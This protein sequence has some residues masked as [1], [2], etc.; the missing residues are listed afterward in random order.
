MPKKTKYFQNCLGVFQGGGVKAIAYVGAYEEAIKRGVFF[1]E[2]VG[3]S[4]GSAIASLIAVGATPDDF[5]KII[6]KL[7]FEKFLKPPK[8]IKGIKYNLPWRIPLHS[9]WQLGKVRRFIR[10]LG[11]YDPSYISEWINEEL[12]IVLNKDKTEDSEGFIPKGEIVKFKHLLI[13][14]SIVATNFRTKRVHIWNTNDNLDD[15]VADAVKASS[16]IPFYFQPIELKY[17]DGGMLSNLPSFTLKPET[18]FDKILAFGFDNEEG[19]IS[20]ITNYKQYFGDLINTVI[21]G[22]VDIQLKLQKEVHLISINT[23]EIE[24][25]DFKKISMDKDGKVKSDLVGSGKRAAQIFFDNEISQIRPRIISTNTAKDIFESFNFLLGCIEFR[26]ETILISDEKPDWV[27]SLFPLLLKWHFDQTDVRVILKSNSEDFNKRAYK[28]RLLKYLGFSVKE[29]TSLPFRG[30]IFDNSKPDGFA[31]IFNRNSTQLTHSVRYTSLNDELVIDALAEKFNSAF[32]ASSSF[33]IKNPLRCN[34]I[35]EKLIFSNL[36]SVSQY[37]SKS[38]EF[39][40]EKIDIK[41]VFFLTRF[42]KGYKYRQ[43]ERIFKVFKDD[44]KI[45]LFSPIALSNG[46]GKDSIM[47]PPIIE[48]HNDKKIVIE[49]NARLFYAFKN[50]AEDELKAV[51]IRNV[52]H[53]LPSSGQF[54]INQ[55]LISDKDKRGNARYEKFDQQHFRYI[56]SEIHNV[57]TSLI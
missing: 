13:P 56:E 15:S 28:I 31:V 34:Q 6:D 17:V 26:S 19:N 45:A 55:I 14:T 40:I 9:G 11:F 50:F 24:A 4:A 41:E 47:T 39:S 52:N 30:F 21:D 12:R 23:G 2:L 3:A 35:H 29:V 51:V 18:I 53:P 10:R 49:G 37:S 46:A 16:A 43:M 38:V 8:R 7:N 32:G 54:T 22:A 27:Y 36:K 44:L 20:K 1:S 5:H 42:I 25:T 33:T 48:I 57:M